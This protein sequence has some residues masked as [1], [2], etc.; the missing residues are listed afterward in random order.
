MSPASSSRLGVLLKAG[1]AAFVEGAAAIPVVGVAIAATMAGLTV[2]LHELEENQDLPDQA[3]DAL[4]QLANEYRQLVAREARRRSRDD[5]NTLEV[6]LTAA[7]EIVTGQGLSARELVEEAGLDANRAAKLTLERGR[8]TLDG[9]YDRAAM[10]L[11]RRLVKDYYRILLQHED[12]FD[13]VAVDAL[14]TLLAR[15]PDCRTQ[16]L[17]RLQAILEN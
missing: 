4:K 16:L 12:A 1:E 15:T 17:P 11:T 7:L 9:L 13:L 5:D 10:E 3:R 14:R 2:Y 8:A 6:A